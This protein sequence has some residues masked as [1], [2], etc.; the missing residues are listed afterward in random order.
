M[1]METGARRSGAA[2]EVPVRFLERLVVIVALAA[3]AQPL[4]GEPGPVP[5]LAPPANLVALEACETLDV[6][7]EPV[8]GA[9]RYAIEVT[10][11]YD[12][13]SSEC[14]NAPDLTSIFTFSVE[15]AIVSIDYANFLRDFGAGLQGPCRIVLVRV[16]GVSPP[17]R[18]I[19]TA[20]DSFAS[21]VPTPNCL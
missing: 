12:S 16:G 18:G 20:Y 10:V 1:R 6:D 11:E 5:G 2:K 3:A 14:S 15:T 7:W 4:R 13:L 19:R 17:E 8:P 21:T 9:S